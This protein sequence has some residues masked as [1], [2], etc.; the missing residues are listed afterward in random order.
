MNLKEKAKQ[1][2]QKLSKYRRH[3]LPFI[4]GAAGVSLFQFAA[5]H[6]PAGWG[7]WLAT[8]PALVILL[9][10]ALARLDDIGLDKMTAVW[11]ARRIGLVLTGIGCV[12]LLMAPFSDQPMFPT[13]IG[14]MLS[15]GVALTW[16]STPSMP[17]WWKYITGEF[18]NR[19]GN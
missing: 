15:W 3:V 19:N 5:S 13:W 18:R 8:A 17:P 14:S 7:S 16:I 9:I 12:Y 11:Q 6:Y 2:A 1:L 10:T 4:G